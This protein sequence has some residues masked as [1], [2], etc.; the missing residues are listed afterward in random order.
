MHRDR[1]RFD[2]ALGHDGWRARRK[3]IE[4]CSEHRGAL[5]SLPPS[6]GTFRNRSPTS[7]EGIAVPAS[8]H[9]PTTGNVGRYTLANR[10]V[11]A[12]M[13][14]SRAELDG[15]PSALAPTYYSQRA[16]VGLIVTEARSPP[17]T[18]RATSPLLAFIPTPMVRDG[19]RC[20][21]RVT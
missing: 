17:T 15:T 5:T 2:V 13:T 20:R 10:L 11:M 14:R 8:C 1:L 21:L 9:S 7:M 19:R 12:P 3:A 6:V 16:S 4:L 18:G